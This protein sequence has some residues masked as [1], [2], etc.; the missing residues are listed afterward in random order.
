MFTIETVRKYGLGL[1][2]F[3]VGVLFAILVPILGSNAER[4]SNI[5]PES[6]EIP[7]AG[8]SKVPASV[9][10]TTDTSSR[11]WDANLYMQVSA[12]YRA[13]C[14]Q[15]Y[16]VAADSLRQKVK[17][18]VDV[19]A[20]DPRKAP[21]VILDLDETVIDNSG[22]Q[23]YQLRSGKSFEMA[24]WLLWEQKGVGEV[25]IIAGAKEFIDFA[26]RLKV[27]VFYITN[28]TQKNKQWTMDAL[29]KLGIEV[30]LDQLLCNES[31][32][33]TNKDDRR[34]AVAKDHDVLLLL[35]DNLRDFDDKF[36][37][38]ADGKSDPAAVAKAIR[39]R[40]DQVDADRKQWGDKWII[41]P[42]PAYGEWAKVLGKSQDLDL[43]VPAAKLND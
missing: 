5:K 4:N 30:P 24:S 7:Y 38:Q 1:I 34:Q 32:T 2:G 22:Y 17:A 42:N 8:E 39:E 27:K 14:L 18:A 23:S 9:L 11:A 12:E 28:R 40:K 20:A 15:A 16:R 33:S 19:E 41:L 21:A 6:T 26:K 37:S 35:G 43:L 31:I 3:T 10:A 13:C 25:G 36:K 29:T